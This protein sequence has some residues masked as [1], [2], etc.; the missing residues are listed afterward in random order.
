MPP[1]GYQ[2]SAVKAIR[3]SANAG[4]NGAAKLLWS[5]QRPL[6]AQRV[7]IYRI[8]NIGDTACAIPAMHAIRRAYPDANLTLLTSPGKTGSVG[9][10]ELLDGV[11]WIDEI[12]VY[13]AEDIATSRGRLALIRDLRARQFDVWIELPAVATSLATQF[14][15]LAVA[16]AVGARWGFGWRY[17]PRIAAQA[18]SAAGDFPDEVDRLLAL[19][20]EAGFVGSGDDFP[21]ELSDSTRRTVT[22]LLDHAGITAADLV[23]AFAPGAKLEPNRW[24]S[25]RFIEVGKSL[26]ARGCRI[27]ILGGASEAPMC[28]RIASAIGRNA[29]SLAGKTTVRESCEVLARCAMLICN[30]SGVQHLAAAVGTPCVSLFTRREFPGMWWPHGPQ[31][32]VLM[33]NV[34]CHTC[35]LDVCPHDNKCI[36]AIGVDEVIAAAGR[37]LTRLPN[38]KPQ[39]A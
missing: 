27:V 32:Q 20:Q 23:I 37:V 19:V 2:A 39:V 15:N 24:P 10:R 22:G 17:E 7:C 36:K 13:D 18:Q 29:A 38:S 8:G 14:R 1:V 28:E 35:F 3:A 9:A 12:V 4:L 30:D 25:E 31:H 33:K 6:D 11:S 5:R 34:E 21:L 16:R 26:A